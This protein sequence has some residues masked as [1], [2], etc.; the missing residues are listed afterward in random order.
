MNYS[1]SQPPN[2]QSPRATHLIK[3]LLLLLQAEK[4]PREEEAAQGKDRAGDRGAPG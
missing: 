2:K 4:D 3:F 1:E